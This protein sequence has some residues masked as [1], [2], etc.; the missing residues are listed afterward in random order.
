MSSICLSRLAF[1]RCIKDLQAIP[2]SEKSS[3]LGI[4]LQNPSCHELSHCLWVADCSKSRMSKTSQN[5]CPRPPQIVP[6]LLRLAAIGVVHKHRATLAG[7]ESH[8][9]HGSSLPPLLISYLLISLPDL[10][11][12][13]PIQVPLASK[14]SRS[15]GQLG[16]LAV[17]ERPVQAVA[18]PHRTC[19]RKCCPT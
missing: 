7:L 2:C 14:R 18:I 11:R 4:V 10:F 16:S 8:K 1:S 19:A 5:K 17:N 9:K 6:C 3:R 13:T 12:Q 15:T